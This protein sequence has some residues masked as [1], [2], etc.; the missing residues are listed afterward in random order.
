ME[1]KSSSKVVKNSELIG[2]KNK[3]SL[4]DEKKQT[5]SHKKFKEY[6]SFTQLRFFLSQM[7]KYPFSYLLYAIPSI[8][9]ILLITELFSLYNFIDYGFTQVTS[10]EE[11]AREVLQSSIYIGLF[12]VL[13]YILDTMVAIFSYTQYKLGLPIFQTFKEALKRYPRY[14]LHRILQF[15]I[16]ASP[17][18]IGFIVF[19]I[20]SFILNA[21]LHPP[22]S[23]D[24]VII[25]VLLM[26]L[27]VMIISVL[28]SAIL[29][30]KYTYLA[31]STLFA[32]SSNII[33]LKE[34]NTKTKG[35]FRNLFFRVLILFL[36]I[37]SFQLFQSVYDSLVSFVPVDTLVLILQII[38][39]LI[40]MFVFYF[41]NTYLFFTFKEEFEEDKRI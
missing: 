27:I 6:I 20:L 36:I 22:S 32:T 35:K 29:S 34:Y 26:L 24:V 3:D 7:H 25:L 30:F 4:I 10:N 21:V 41:I 40:S 39:V 12:V 9:V 5:S 19:V 15:L 16:I 23:S 14:L 28:I 38:G 2:I 18:L 31:V 13:Y 17:L 8:L 11:I 37:A 33:V 1:K